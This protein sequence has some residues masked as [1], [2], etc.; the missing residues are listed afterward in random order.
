MSSSEG[1][2]L[3]GF[4]RNREIGIDVECIRDIPEMFQIVNL[5]FSAREIQVYR[6]LSEQL[7]R[8]AL[9]ACWTRKEAFVKA[10][11]DGLSRPLNKLR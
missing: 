6:A 9:F 4:S 5:I 2:A 8:E 3:Y 11:G 10:T 7:K 1:L